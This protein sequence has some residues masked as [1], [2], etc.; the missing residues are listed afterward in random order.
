MRFAIL[1]AMALAGAAYAVE[2]TIAVGTKAGDLVFKPD[3]V[4]AAAGDT[5]V[6]K[7]WPKNHS[8]C[9]GRIQQPLCTRGQ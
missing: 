7:F 9:P 4:T 8:G 5:V 1:F 3:N 6:F 2:H